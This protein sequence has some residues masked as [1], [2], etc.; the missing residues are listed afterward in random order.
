LRSILAPGL[1]ASMD[2]WTFS[3]ATTGKDRIAAMKPKKS[4]SLHFI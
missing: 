2:K 4:G 1:E 3:A